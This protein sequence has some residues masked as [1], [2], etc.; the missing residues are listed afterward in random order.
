M[1]RLI[2][3]EVNKYSE[4]NESY[5]INAIAEVENFIKGKIKKY[6]TDNR[7]LEEKLIDILKEI[8]IKGDSIEFKNLFS[9]KKELK[10]IESKRNS[11][12]HGEKFKFKE[13]SKY[14]ESIGR[15]L[16]VIL[17]IIFSVVMYK[18]LDKNMWKPLLN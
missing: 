17:T 3:E 8:G 4:Y 6:S 5:S 12:G 7:R 15:V 13:K 16:Y 11:I 1:K 10:I 14:D 18:D 9:L 2:K